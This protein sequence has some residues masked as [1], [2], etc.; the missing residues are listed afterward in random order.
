MALLRISEEIV[1]GPGTA[2]IAYHGQDEGV[3]VGEKLR[4]SGW[5]TTRIPNDDPFALRAVD[6]LKV[7]QELCQQQYSTSPLNITDSML[8]AGWVE[9]GRDACSGDSGG[10]LTDNASSVLVGL[11]SWGRGCAEPD[12]SGVYARVASFSDWITSNIEE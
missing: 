2:N 6:V 5:G 3:A 7:D 12:T 8:C 10:P 4:V 9:G 1:F 11:V